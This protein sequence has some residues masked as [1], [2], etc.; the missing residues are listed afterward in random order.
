MDQIS[1]QN[2]IATAMQRMVDGRKALTTEGLS[3]D[4]LIMLNDGQKSIIGIFNDA[5]ASG[6]VDLM[7][8][9]MMF[10]TAQ[11]L[12][13]ND[14]AEEVARSSAETA[15][16]K[17]QDAVLSLKAV[18]TDCYS[19]V[20]DCIPHS[21]NYRHGKYPRDSFHIACDSDRMRIMKGLTEFGHSPAMLDLAKT[22]RD[23]VDA[24]QSAYCNLQE[25]ALI[26]ENNHVQ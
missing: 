21:K 25:A 5:I 26:K 9:A 17:F 22:R 3:N 14:V 1:L 6:N 20:D 16:A 13:Q 7:L 2:S 15:M 18:K 19:V 8:D 24:A 12:V 11:E 23:L 10:Y 4:G